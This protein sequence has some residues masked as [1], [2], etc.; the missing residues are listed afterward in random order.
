MARAR[1]SV[2]AVAGTL[3]NAELLEL[4]REELVR[5]ATNVF[6][7]RRFDK[8]SVNEIAE[9]CGWS[10]GS[11]YRYVSSKEDI[12]VLVCDEIF[13]SLS[14]DELRDAADEDPVAAFE[15][16]FGGYCDSVHKN[17]RQVLLMYREYTQLPP[18]AQK[19]FR[20][21][22]SDVYELLAGIVR[23]GVATGAFACE[24]PHVFA[25]DCVMR[26]HTLA[27]KEWAL[28]RT[29]YKRMRRLLVSWSLRALAA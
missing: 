8:A 13:R 9:R 3:K 25:V 1:H 21:R 26:A 2:P 12:L 20:Q 11:L 10:I 24:E 19:H 22:E 6:V 18:Q 7:E 27:L 15:A 23:R 16:A 14:I 29:S 28:G 4:R 5:C 17:R